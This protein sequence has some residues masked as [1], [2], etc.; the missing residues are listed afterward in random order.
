[1]SKQVMREVSVRAMCSRRTGDSYSSSP[2]QRSTL[3]PTLDLVL[4]PEPHWEYWLNLKVGRPP[5]RWHP[6]NQLAHHA[7]LP[8]RIVTC[9]FLDHSL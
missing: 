7:G 9:D 1:M 4:G 8:Y 5:S 6:A 3:T 2:N